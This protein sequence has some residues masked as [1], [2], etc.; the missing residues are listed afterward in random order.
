MCLE[1]NS[2]DEHE[3]LCHF[4]S[5]DDYRP[6]AADAEDDSHKWAHSMILFQVIPEV[7]ES[8]S[9]EDRLSTM[10]ENMKSL[11]ASIRER[12]DE[13]SERMRN[14]EV[15]IRERENEFGVRLQR[16]EGML[17]QLVTKLVGKQ[18]QDSDNFR[19]S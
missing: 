18:P 16:L 7:S 9:V 15:S 2:K 19:Y 5:R 8:P 12:E 14:L 4:A 17:A 3:R 6:G 13:F 1:C 10:E 11:E